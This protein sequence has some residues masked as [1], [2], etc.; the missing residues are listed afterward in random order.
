VTNIV[1]APASIFMTT[2]SVTTNTLDQ[3]GYDAIS[4]SLFQVIGSATLGSW[5]TY[6]FGCTNDNAAA[7]PLADPD[8]DGQNNMTEFLAGTDPTSAASLFHL[9][10]AKIEGND[11]R[12]SWMCGGGRTNVLQYTTNLGGSWFN[13]NTNIVLSEYGDVTTNYLD[14]GSI[15]N[16]PARF[17]RVQLVQ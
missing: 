3:A 7:D 4:N 5:L 15:T 10:P 9:L 6:Y 12:V 13:I 17:Y 11:L 14:I 1:D 8:G 16:G 2:N